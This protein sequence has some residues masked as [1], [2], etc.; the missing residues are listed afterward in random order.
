LHEVETGAYLIARSEVTFADWMAFLE[1]LPPAERAA[2]M[3]GSRRAINLLQ[4]EQVPGGRWRLTLRP[5]A[6]DY[7]ALDGEPIRYGKRERRAVQDWRRFPVAAVSFEDAVAYAAWLNRT[8]RMPGARLCTEREWERAARGADGR[9]YPSGD[10]L[11]PD[12]ANYDVTYGREPLGYGPD[13]VGS[14]P[15]SRSPFGVDDLAGNVWEWTLSDEDPNT[16]TARG[17]SWYHSD[18]T[19]HVANHDRV[20]PTLREPLVGLRLCA[21]PRHR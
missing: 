18:L 20:E 3:P 21:T 6:A 8:G 9:R 10:W 4:L 16:P 13:E 2:R 12:D 19:A 7:T 5:S 1:A 14:H 15:R 17:G 11:A